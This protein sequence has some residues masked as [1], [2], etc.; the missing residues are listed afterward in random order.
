MVRRSL[1]WILGVENITLPESI[2]LVLLVVLPMIYSAI[3]NPSMIA[4]A[5]G[6]FAGLAYLIAVYT[7]A[8]RRDE[9]NEP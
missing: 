6:I 9:Y 2:C 4:S 7:S 8:S 3:F 1:G 5:F